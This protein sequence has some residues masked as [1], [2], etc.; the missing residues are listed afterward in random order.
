MKEFLNT[1]DNVFSYEN[2]IK[3]LEKSSFYFK[4][5]VYFECSICK[6]IKEKRLYPNKSD[7][8]LTYICRECNY[9][10][11][12]IEKYGVEN[13]SKLPSVINKAKN[14]CLKKYGVDN[15]SKSE[16][17]KDLIRKT[18]KASDEKTR[19]KY[20]NTCLKKYGV[21]N[22]AKS[23]LVRNKTEKTNIERYGV[24]APCQN[25][26]IFKKCFKNI[27]YDN[28]YFD[29]SWELAY[30]I[31]CK[32]N[33]KNI[34]RNTKLYK[35]SNG[36]YCCPDFIVDGQLV[37]IKGDHLKNTESYKYKQKFYDENNVKVLSYEDLVPIFK[38]VYSFMKENNLPLPRI[39][40]KRNIF[41]I[42]NIE[43]LKD[44]KNKNCKIQY[45]CTNCGAMNITGVKI[46]EHFN[47]LLCKKCRKKEK[48]TNLI[49]Q[50]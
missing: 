15:A 20:R 5:Y 41:L 43:Q 50:C 42:D 47:N 35:L 27:K 32:Q 3:F 6:K 34:E 9:K 7:F 46:L 30:Y 26:K 45:V 49:N 23:E 25:E 40:T 11:T 17:I 21:D 13:P 48:T 31:W 37:E 18:N 28:I 1:K 33:S 44:Y 2:K 14:T 22:A 24:K 10:K 16:H 4:K 38:L 39:K 8:G 36:S 12:S 29:S 19:Q